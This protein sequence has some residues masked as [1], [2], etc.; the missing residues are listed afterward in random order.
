MKKLLLII[1]ILIFISCQRYD[2]PILNAAN[3]PFIVNK[4][5]SYDSNFSAYYSKQGKGTGKYTMVVIARIILPTGMYNV[6]DT[7]ILKR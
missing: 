2:T 3:K 4:V 5:E 1:S 6:G 7:I